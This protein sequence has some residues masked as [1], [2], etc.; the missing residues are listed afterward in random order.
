MTQQRVS[1]VV[2]TSQLPATVTMTVQGALGQSVNLQQWQ[3]STG[4]LLLSVDSSGNLVAPSASTTAARFRYFDGTG[5][6][7]T[8]ID[9][10][11]VAGSLS[12]IA[13]S[14]TAAS[15]IVKGAASQTGSLQ[16][17]QLS[18]AT[19]TVVIDSIGRTSVGT[20][21]VY[22]VNQFGRFSARGNGAQESY[23]MDINGS[24]SATALGAV[25]RIRTAVAT[26]PGLV[27]QGFSAQTGDLQRWNNSSGTVLFSI[28]SNGRVSTNQ[29]TNFGFPIAS[30]IFDAQNN[31]S[32]DTDAAR[33][34]MLVRGAA[35][36]TADLQVWQNNTPTTLTAITAAGTINFA[37]GNTSA[38]A[39]IGAITAPLMVAGYITMQVAGT[40]VKVPYYNN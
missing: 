14:T 19:A 1:P 34:V 16:Q 24:T 11:I 26:E 4:G 40:T 30:A 32:N 17:W 37:S 13:R 3:S 18:D 20:S 31:F 15:V 10:Q 33:V 25:V 28:L 23:S 21:N 36:Q 7:G 29:R 35:S 6:V 22:G 8:Y 5:A 39:T 12:M 2:I 9:T 38:T 27:V